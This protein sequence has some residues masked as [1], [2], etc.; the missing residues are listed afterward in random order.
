MSDDVDADIIKKIRAAKVLKGGSYIAENTK[1]R[2]T[3]IRG[4]RQKGFNGEAII[5]DVLIKES[6]AKSPEDR[7]DKVGSKVGMYFP[8]DKKGVAG[9]MAWNNLATLLAALTN[10][11][12][13]SE[14]DLE[15]GLKGLL[16]KDQLFRGFDFAFDTKV[17]VKDGKRRSYPL[18]LPTNNE[19]K[20]VQEERARLDKDYPLP[21]ATK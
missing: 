3:V 21:A 2:A 15:E 11:E 13:I 19:P 17:K 8:L 12:E 18:P 5:V 7:P 14:A 6:I 1:G 9:E 16:G 4:F 10:Q 20:L